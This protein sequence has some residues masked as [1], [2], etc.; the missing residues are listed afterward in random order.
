MCSIERDPRRQDHAICTAVAP[1]T[2]FTERTK[3]TG[4]AQGPALVFKFRRIRTQNSRS[5]IRSHAR[6]RNVSQVR[7]ASRGL[8]QVI[9]S[10]SCNRQAA[11]PWGASG[12]S[13]PMRRGS[14]AQPRSTGQGRGPCESRHGVV[15]QAIPGLAA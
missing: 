13:H 10:L 4:A 1:E 15:L 9:F 6:T 3:A 12:W 5:T 8:T 7:P 2:V 11:L 14:G